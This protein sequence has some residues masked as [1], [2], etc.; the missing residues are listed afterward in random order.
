M[1][2]GRLDAAN[3]EDFFAFTIPEGLGPYHAT[4][5][6]G[7]LTADAD[8]K[9]LDATG[10]VL[11]GSVAAGTRAEAVYRTLGPG[12]YFVRVYTFDGGSTPYGLTVSIAASGGLPHPSGETVALV[13]DGVPLAELVYPA[14]LAS[15]D[16]R[17]L[18]AG[19]LQQYVA[20]LSGAK[21]DLAADNAQD[22]AAHAGL[23]RPADRR[24]DPR[25]AARP[26]RRIAG[27]PREFG[28]ARAGGRH[29]SASRVLRLAARA[30]PS[31]PD[32]EFASPVAF[33]VSTLLQEN[34]GVTW[35]AP[36]EEWTDLPEGKFG[37]LSVTVRE[38]VTV[39]DATPHAWSRGKWDEESE[40]LRR[41]RVDGFETG[42]VQQSYAWKKPFNQVQ[43]VSTTSIPIVM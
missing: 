30:D 21:L 41:N 19:D 36:G 4:I 24:S 14:G 7:G 42:F 13:A 23:R 17:L 22:P 26:V 39:A 31:I 9:L 10:K 34:L 20:R 5:E 2:S 35:L 1:V 6:L 38:G 11:A 27:R 18:S 16:L 15:G 40:W 3:S 43:D 37:E 25:R 29:L 28:V 12:D 8:L 32:K 33:A